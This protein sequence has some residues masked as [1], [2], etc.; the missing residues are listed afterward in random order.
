M[1]EQS[2][3]TLSIKTDFDFFKGFKTVPLIL[4]GDCGFADLAV[5]S[6][7][8]LSHLTPPNQS[9]QYR[10]DIDPIDT[11]DHAFDQHVKLLGWF[12]V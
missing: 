6:I 4:G 8:S 2:K 5:I 1:N 7:I 3:V 10:F 12:G 9:M 11:P